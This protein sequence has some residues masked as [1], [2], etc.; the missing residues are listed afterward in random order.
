MHPTK[1]EVHFLD[2]EFILN[3]LEEEV[4]KVLE[5]Q[6][7]GRRFAVQT[8]LPFAKAQALGKGQA[9]VGIGASDGPG[10]QS[11]PLVPLAEVRNLV[12]TLVGVIIAFFSCSYLQCLEGRGLGCAFFHSFVEPF[13]CQFCLSFGRFFENVHEPIMHVPLSTIKIYISNTSK[14]D[15]ESLT[16]S[17][18][19]F[20]DQR[21]CFVCRG[22][23]SFC[24]WLSNYFGL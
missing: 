23:F 4:R 20:S 15:H 14:K 9:P 22:A 24:F 8:A 7:A 2:Q 13:S 10:Q 17:V 1:K 21:K 12:L 5:G 11:T 18:V 16:A 3:Y 6:N 19:Y